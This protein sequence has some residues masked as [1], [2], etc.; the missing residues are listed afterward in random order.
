ME[1]NDELIKK[2]KNHF[3]SHEQKERKS[4]FQ[5]WLIFRLEEKIPKLRKW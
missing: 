2:Q 4:D 3:Y 5:N 1:I